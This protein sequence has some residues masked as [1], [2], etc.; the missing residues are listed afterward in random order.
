MQFPK[1]LRF[2]ELANRS[3]IV[4]GWSRPEWD[5][6]GRRAGSRVECKSVDHALFEDSEADPKKPSSALSL[7]GRQAAQL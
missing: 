7:E 5:S 6:K 4:E 2:C 3:A 1:P